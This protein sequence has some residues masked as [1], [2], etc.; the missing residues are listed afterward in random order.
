MRSMRLESSRCVLLT[1]ITAALLC[2]SLAQPSYGR[3]A[4]SR[5]E[6]RP[7]TGAQAVSVSTPLLGA[8]VGT[9]D[10]GDAGCARFELRPSDRY[11]DIEVLDAHGLPVYAVVWGP[12]GNEV[13]DLCGTTDHPI[14][15]P[16]GYI[17]VWPTKGTCHDTPH[18]SVATT[19]EIT[20][21]FSR[22]P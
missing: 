11:I 14:P 6:T 20:A 21:T 10:A 4:R 18:P 13:G 15:S 12:G 9:C 2:A 5:S 7:Y 16:G 3:S 17:D 22:R 19:G 8:Y 1:G